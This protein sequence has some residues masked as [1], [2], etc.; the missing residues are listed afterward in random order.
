[1]K[2]SILPAAFLCAFLGLGS[3]TAEDR[4]DHFTGLP[5]ETLEVAVHNFSEYNKRLAAIVAKEE[6]NASD[7]ATVHELTYTLENA[8]EKINDELAALAD[9]LEDV[10][11]ASETGDAVSTLAKGRAYLSTARTVIP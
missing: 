6:L 2:Y 3:A 11:V 7:L 4:V 1:M 8:L 9:L 10:H 5:A